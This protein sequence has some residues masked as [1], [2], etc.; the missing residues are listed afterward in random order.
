MSA[1]FDLDNVCCVR[2]GVRVPDCEESFVPLGML[3]HG[4]PI[5]EALCA[6]CRAK[7]GV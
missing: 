3:G 2:C 7:E 4:I 5:E 1:L 6:K